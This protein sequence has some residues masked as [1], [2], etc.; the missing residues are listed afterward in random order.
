MSELNKQKLIVA[1]ALTLLV[2]APYYALEQLR[3]FPAQ[4]IK[5]TAVD[6]WVSFDDRAVF[7][8][9]SLYLLLPLPVMLI[10]RFEELRR[11][12]S[13]LAIIAAV[14]H[15][16]FLLYPTSVPLPRPLAGEANFV[17]ALMTQI[18]QPLNACPSL[19]ASL[20]VFAALW[21]GQLLRGKRAGALLTAGIWLWVVTI[22]YSTLASRQHLVWDLVAGAALGASVYFGVELMKRGMN[23]SMPKTAANE[24]SPAQWR[25]AQARLALARC[26]GDEL[27]RLR[28]CSLKKR[29]CELA[30]FL[31]ILA[32]GL[33]AGVAIN[34]AGFSV[35]ATALRY[36]LMAAGILITALAINSLVLLMHEGMHNTLFA[37]QRWN[38]WVSV[39]LGA[40]FLMSF[41]A[42]QVMHTRHHDYLGDARDPDDYHNY[43]HN[44]S[45]VW[46]LH[47]MRLTVGPLLYIFLIPLLAFKHGSAAQRRR[48]AVEYALLAAAYS[49]ILAAVPFDLLLYVWLL[50]LLLVGQMTAIRGFTQHGIT[51][52]TDPYL[53]SRSITANRLTA[54]F[55]LNENYHLE[56]HLF[57]EVPSYHLRRLHELLWPRLPYAVT[58][59]SYVGFLFRFFRATLRLDETPIGMTTIA[60][61]TAPVEKHG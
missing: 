25:T 14:S 43:S 3:L 28:G 18:D 50:P 22:L 16:F 24:L 20:A 57:P 39:A 6:R 51:D 4:P 49:A 46:A 26:L 27:P 33:A 11:A 45:L 7:V 60:A 29:L 52:A 47:F 5:L 37:S 40:T 30:I 15:L 54:F 44:R 17:Y 35:K 58:G 31:S 9:L 56:H 10:T 2:S 61:N 19:H 59:M 42:Y 34:L 41:S 55:L 48:V 36:A 12:A 38:R 1:A 32:G 13:G 53:A 8:Y 21:C 23:Q